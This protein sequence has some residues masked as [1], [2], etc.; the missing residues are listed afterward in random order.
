MGLISKGDKLAVDSSGTTIIAKGTKITGKID[1]ACKL[2]IDGEID[3]TV[4]SSNIVAIGSSGLIRGEVFSEKLMVSGHLEGN[5]DCE[6][7]DIL[8][9]G[10]IRGDIVS[11]NLIIESQGKFEGQSKIRVEG[12]APGSSFARDEDAEA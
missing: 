11:I 10:S 9:G 5:A 4:H 6:S 12:G 1:I 8:A 7:I 2:H 3:G